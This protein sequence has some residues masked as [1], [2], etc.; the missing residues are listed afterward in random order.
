MVCSDEAPGL[1]NR[2]AGAPQRGNGGHRDRKRTKLPAPSCYQ[3][4]QLGEQGWGPRRG[5]PWRPVALVPVC[6][7]TPGWPSLGK[8]G[9][10]M[11]PS[12]YGPSLSLGWASGVRVGAP[13][14]RIGLGWARKTHV[15]VTLEVPA[16]SGRQDSLLCNRVLLCASTS[17]R[18]VVLTGLGAKGCVALWL[19]RTQELGSLMQASTAHSSPTPCG[20]FLH[21]PREDC[22]TWSPRLQAFL[23]LPHSFRR[24]QTS[25]PYTDRAPQGQ[26]S[27]GG[28]AQRRRPGGVR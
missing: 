7:R 2:M 13:V 23:Q 5:C 3:R 18:C 11:V 16:L 14:P 12:T 15:S 1:P 22:A 8:P 27:G 28:L 20:L 25:P 17:P 4:S 19:E 6:S 26:V 10:G 21:V 24:V 9:T